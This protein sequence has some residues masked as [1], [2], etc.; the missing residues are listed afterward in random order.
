MSHA[1][2]FAKSPPHLSASVQA[3][4]DTASIASHTCHLQQAIHCL[5]CLACRQPVGATC[6]QRRSHCV[7]SVMHTKPS[8]RYICSHLLGVQAN[9]GARA[10]P[11]IS[12]CTAVSPLFISISVWWT[13]CP[14]RHGWKLRRLLDSSTLTS[15]SSCWCRKVL[16]TTCTTN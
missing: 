9:W 10:S 14:T 1:N 5:T 12:N 8:V 2:H 15:A 11:C 4:G 6:S 16:P 7:S 3:T 13:D